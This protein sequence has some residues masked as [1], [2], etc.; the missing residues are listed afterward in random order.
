MIVKIAVIPVAGI[1]FAVH[2][3]A[4]KLR[5]KEDANLFH[6]LLAFL[7]TLISLALDFLIVVLLWVMADGFIDG[8]K[9]L[10]TMDSKG[11]TLLFLVLM[12]LLMVLVGK[13]LLT[14]LMILFEGRENK[15]R[16]K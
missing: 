1:F 7:L 3:F 6:K 12:G 9:N 8:I 16:T 14:L 15:E 11:A 13:L 4:A 2:Y 5:W 10:F